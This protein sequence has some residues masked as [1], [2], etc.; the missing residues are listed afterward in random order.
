MKQL[1]HYPFSVI[2]CVCVCAEVLLY[3]RLLPRYID[4]CRESNNTN[5]VIVNTRECVCVFVR[6]LKPNNTQSINNQ[7]PHTTPSTYGTHDN[8]NSRGDN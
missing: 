1:H 6:K 3:S 5:P 7:L 4:M 8:N 2:V